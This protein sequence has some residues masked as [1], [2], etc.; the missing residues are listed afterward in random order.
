MSLC[1]MTK[2][3]IYLLLT[4][5]HYNYTKMSRFTPILSIM[6]NC[7]KLFLF[8]HFSFCV[9]TWI[10]HLPI[11]INAMLNLSCYYYHYYYYYLFIYWLWW[12][13]QQVA[14]LLMDTQGAFDS[15]ST[16][17]DCATIFALSTM[18]SSTQVMYTAKS[19]WTVSLDNKN[20]ILNLN[21]HSRHII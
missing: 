17:K 8:A 6:F 10:S 21:N 19:V 18:T 13:L 16:V 15:S 1:H 7:F 20:K 5:D 4:V 9:S 14:V 11:A 2:F 3:S 12:F